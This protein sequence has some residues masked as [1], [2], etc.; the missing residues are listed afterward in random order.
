MLLLRANRRKV[1]VRFVRPKWKIKSR[2]HPKVVWIKEN[3]LGSVALPHGQAV[4]RKSPWNPG[5][6]T[7][8]SLPPL[9]NDPT[10]SPE[11]LSAV[12]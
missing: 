10:Q 4:Q 9:R 12:T 7:G 11:P 1:L 8:V 3:Q 6:P 2:L 5:S